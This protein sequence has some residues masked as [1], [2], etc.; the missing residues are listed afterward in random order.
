MPEER[1]LMEPRLMAENRDD[2]AAVVDLEEPS[3]ATKTSFAGGKD[4]SEHH[5]RTPGADRPPVAEPSEANHDGDDSYLL[6]RV[7]SSA[8][9]LADKLENE[10]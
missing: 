2:Q 5:Q 9:S 1:T 4:V 8:Q 10:G 7:R 6:G 3:P